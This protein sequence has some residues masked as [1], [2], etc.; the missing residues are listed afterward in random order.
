MMMSKVM[1]IV[2]IPYLCS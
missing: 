1:N 2:I